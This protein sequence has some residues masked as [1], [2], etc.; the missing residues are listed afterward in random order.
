MH[1]RFHTNPRTD[2]YAGS[3]AA[4]DRNTHADFN[5]YRYSSPD[6]DACAVAHAHAIAD[7]NPCSSSHQHAGT[8][9][10]AYSDAH[11]GADRDAK[12]HTD[13]RPVGIA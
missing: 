1:L 9:P 13:S 2:R 10:Y 6:S 3:R 12:A 5:S 8:C 4:S 11:G 7:R